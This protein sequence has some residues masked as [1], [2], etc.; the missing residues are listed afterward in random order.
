MVKTVPITNFPGK[1]VTRFEVVLCFWNYLLI[2]NYKNSSYLNWMEGIS[3]KNQNF[4]K[5]ASTAG[6]WLL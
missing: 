4:S 5:G 6:R 2:I 3:W 1:L